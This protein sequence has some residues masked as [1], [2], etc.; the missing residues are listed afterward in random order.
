MLSHRHSLKFHCWLHVPVNPVRCGEAEPQDCLRVLKQVKHGFG[1]D[2]LAFES[3]DILDHLNGL[4]STNTVQFLEVQFN[5]YQT[6][7]LIRDHDSSQQN[8]FSWKP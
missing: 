2:F 4:A 7:I 8:V 5:G 1:A 6:F 3:S